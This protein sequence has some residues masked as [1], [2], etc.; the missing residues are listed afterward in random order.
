MAA[1]S[2]AHICEYCAS[3][4]AIAAVFCPKT[5]VATSVASC[6]RLAVTTGGGT[7]AAN[8]ASKAV[9]AASACVAVRSAGAAV[10][11]IPATYGAAA[12]VIAA[13]AGPRHSSPVS[14]E[15]VEPYDSAAERNSAANA[16]QAEAAASSGRDPAPEYMRAEL[17]SGGSIPKSSV[18]NIVSPLS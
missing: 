14:A 18:A 1:A 4:A 8:A 15:T 11:L 13:D 10:S 5:L 6:A 12:A 16:F 2:C 3:V 9:A 7:V 17:I